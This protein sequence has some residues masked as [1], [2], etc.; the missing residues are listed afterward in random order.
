M[1]TM[2]TTCEYFAFDQGVTVF[3]RDNGT[4]WYISVISKFEP[5]DGRMCVLE[6]DGHGVVR[7]TEKEAKRMEFLN[8]LFYA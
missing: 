8:C 1:N 3:R 2:T 7:I 6:E 5:M 4:Q